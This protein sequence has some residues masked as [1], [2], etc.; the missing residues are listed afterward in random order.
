[1]KKI[2]IYSAFLFV[3]LFAS[4]LIANAQSNNASVKQETTQQVAPV[5]AF[6][7]VESLDNLRNRVEDAYITYQN[8]PADKAEALGAD[9]RHQRRLY[10][11]ELEQSTKTYPKATET[12]QKIRDEIFRISR[13]TR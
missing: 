6:F 7:K 2:F 5:E 1:M 12:G 11:V 13:D 9:F 10:L 3:A 4:V 8:A